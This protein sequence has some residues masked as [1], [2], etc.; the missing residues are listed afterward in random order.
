[1]TLAN[2]ILDTRA[3]ADLGAMTFAARDPV[4]I[5]RKFR[6]TAHRGITPLRTVMSGASVSQGADGAASTVVASATTAFGG[7]TIPPNDPRI[8]DVGGRFALATDRYSGAG[9]VGL[10]GTGV[11]GCGGQGQMFGTDSQTFDVCANPGA[12]TSAIAVYATDLETGVRARISASDQVGTGASSFRY[13][14]YD[15]GSRRNRIIEI[16]A[17]SIVSLRGYNVEAS[18]SIWKITRPEEP[19]V[20]VVWDSYGEG[21]VSQA[22]QSTLLAKTTVAH[23]FGEVLGVHNVWSKSRGG[24]GFL[25]GGGNITTF[26]ARIAAGD[27]DVANCGDLDMLLM[28]GSVN[29][30]VGVNAAYTDAAL[31][32][33]FTGAW[34]AAAAKQANALMVGCPPESTTNRP[35]SQ[36]RCDLMKAA[37]LAVA[38]L[39]P[40]PA[41][42]L[43][44]DGSPSG[45]NWMSNASPARNAVIVG[46]D[47]THL[48]DIGQPYLG[49]RMG[50]SALDQIVALAG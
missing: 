17:T 34:T 47:N 13:Y 12:V 45:E 9:A 22:S 8:T 36:T 24:T 32:P 50:Q 43:W 2:G 7:A 1:M 37:F 26:G 10:D 15:F 33:A 11:R 49:R 5:A 31:I 48:N 4:T 40:K 46:S 42:F 35:V 19:K 14:K 18:S 25:N 20:C 28:P 30:D 21:T 23:Y 6:R 16:F 38:A 29:D 41:R 27:I 39:D 44:L 3:L